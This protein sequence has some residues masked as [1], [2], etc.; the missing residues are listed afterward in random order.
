MS[1]EEKTKLNLSYRA[2][3]DLIIGAG[4]LLENGSFE[5]YED[6]LHFFEKPHKWR[7]EL[8]ELNFEV[9]LK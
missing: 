3:D 5:S 7:L 6:M 9:E 2:S 8:E 1:D 4:A